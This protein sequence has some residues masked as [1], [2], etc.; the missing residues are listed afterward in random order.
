MLPFPATFF[1]LSTDRPSASQTNRLRTPQRP[2]ASPL[3]TP[4]ETA[5]ATLRRYFRN[6]TPCRSLFP[7][8]ASFYNLLADRPSTTKPTTAETPQRPTAS[9]SE[10]P[11]GPPA[12]PFAAISETK[13]HTGPYFLSPQPFST[14]QPLPLDQPYQPPPDTAATNRVP[15]KLPRGPPEQPSAAIS[16][17]KTHTGPYFL[18]PQPSRPLFSTPDPPVP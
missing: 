2:T 18:S 6:K 7:C 16:E 5:R 14:S 10:L 15:Q 4:Q 1:S 3:R 13:T 12:H 8:P 9:P 11:R 17:T